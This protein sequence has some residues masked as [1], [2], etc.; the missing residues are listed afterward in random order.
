M[1]FHVKI[2]LI[3]SCIYIAPTYASDSGVKMH[4]TSSGD[5]K[6]LYTFIKKVG[7]LIE[8]KYGM[9]LCETGGGVD[10]GI[11]LISM[12]FNRFGCQLTEAKARHYIVACLNDI[13]AYINQDINLRS[14]LKIYPFTVKNLDI[15][16]FNHLEKGADVFAPFIGTI[17]AYRGKIAYLTYDEADVFSYKTE[18]Y[19]TYAEAVSIL[20]TD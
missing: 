5:G 14:H 9:S 20:A 13:L 8:R 3:L 17:S 15:A 7:V 19:E 11:W 6:V 16:I 1:K 10:T 18:K 12:S 4:S 2:I